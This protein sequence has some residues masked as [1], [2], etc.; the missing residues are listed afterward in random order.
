ML[1]VTEIRERL[2]Q[3]FLERNRQLLG[4]VAPRGKGKLGL[5]IVG[6]NAVM[7]KT[8]STVRFTSLDRGFERPVTAQ[9]P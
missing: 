9:V 6:V 1:S 8:Q 7:C 3:F 2:V 4:H 5:P